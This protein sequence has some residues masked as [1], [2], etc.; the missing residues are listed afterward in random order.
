MNASEA[1]EIANKVAGFD[2][3][4]SRLLEDIA[5]YAAKGY[6]RRETYAFGDAE[7]RALPE[8]AEELRERGYKVELPWLTRHLG[9]IKV[10]W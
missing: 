8:V 4:L 1:A 3:L 6:L 10:S 9:H 7:L 5:Y 2:R